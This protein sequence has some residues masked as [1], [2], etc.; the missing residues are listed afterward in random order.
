MISSTSS[1]LKVC[2]EHLSLFSE[3]TTDPSSILLKKVTYLYIFKGFSF[4]KFSG[5]ITKFLGGYLLGNFFTISWISLCLS[6]FLIYI[7][8]GES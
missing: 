3:F 4:N 7:K 2:F 6:S 1:S 5:W 8:L